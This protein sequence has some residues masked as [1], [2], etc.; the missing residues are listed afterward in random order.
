M[1]LT[2]TTLIIAI[3]VAM[4]FYAWNKPE[5]FQKWVMNAYMVKERKQYGRFITSGFIHSDIPHLL[6]N[7]IAL[8]SFGSILEQIYY[9]YLG[10]IGIFLYPLLYLVAIVTSEIPS[11]LKHKNNY[12]YNSLGASGAVSA[13]VLS[14]ILFYPLDD[15]ILFF[16]IRLPGFVVGILYIVYSYYQS[17][18][19]SD[20]IN[21]DAHLYGAFSG[22][23]F[24]VFIHPQVIPDFIATVGQYLFHLRIF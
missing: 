11:Y 14:S 17:K 18:N 19:S 4:S 2:L 22:I 21:H 13:V 15:V 7:M 6:L 20:N 5:I 3:T 9:G 16:F 1:G 24:S 23:V 8:Y 10:A 12:Y